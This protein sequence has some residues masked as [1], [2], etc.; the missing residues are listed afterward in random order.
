[1]VTLAILIS[2]VRQSSV[3]LFWYAEGQ[4][5]MLEQDILK[6]ESASMEMLQISL[7]L[8]KYAI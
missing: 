7:K 3:H 1:M 2:V 8:N 4:G 5:D 6:E